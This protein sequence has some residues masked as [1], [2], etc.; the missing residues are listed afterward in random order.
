MLR[1][2]R[3]ERNPSVAVGKA[4]DAPQRRRSVIKPPSFGLLGGRSAIPHF[5]PANTLSIFRMIRSAHS[6]AEATSDSVLGLGRLSNRSSVV[7]R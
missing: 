7:F 1:R 3:T 5:D 2:L 6:T 4:P